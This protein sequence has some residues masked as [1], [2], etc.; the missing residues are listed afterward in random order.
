MAPEYAR[1]G[2]FSVKSD[3]FSFG[4]IVLEIVSGQKN[5]GFHNEGNVEHLLSFVCLP[6]SSS[7]L[8]LEVLEKE[9]RN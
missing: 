1:Q 6:S 4:V 5:G 9:I 8:P 7:S 2:K 3:A